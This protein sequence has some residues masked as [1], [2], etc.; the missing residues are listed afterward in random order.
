[1]KIEVQTR[2]G[3]NRLLDIEIPGT[4]VSGEINRAST[5]MA[6]FARVPGFRPG[7]VP[8]SVIKT[9]YKTE[10]RQE[11]L[12]NLLP[13]AVETAVE[14]HKLRP[15]GEPNVESLEFADDNTLK[16]GVVIEIYPEFTLAEYKGL[17]LTKKVF[18]ITDEDVERAIK[19]LVEAEAELV[20]VDDEGREATDGDFVSIDLDGAYVEEEGH[21][22]H[23]HHEPIKATDVQIEIGGENVQS[24]FSDALRGAKVGDTRTFT[25]V[26]K[27]ESSAPEFAGHTIEYTARV[28][29]I[30]VREVPEFD[31]EFASQYG[32][33]EH[34]TADALR[35][36][37]RTNLEKQAASRTERAFQDVLSDALVNANEFP[38][39]AS[40]VDTFA[41]ERVDRMIQ[42]FSQQ[43]IDPREL[44]LD[45]Q[46]VSRSAI[47]Q[48]EREVRGM[49]I[50]DRIAEAE[51]INPTDEDVEAEI[52]R[53]AEAL[54]QPLAQLR[55]RL[56]KEGG[57]DSIRHQMRSRKALDLVVEAARVTVEEVT[58]LHA[59]EPKAEDAQPTDGEAAVEE[60]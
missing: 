5:E 32:E 39:P 49:F 48:A 29:A 25:V 38:V 55:A 18:K 20:A 21:E 54:N 6:R 23:H 12:R 42:M 59:G 1:M 2:E 34:E 47:Q 60:S 31:D 4:I 16:I 17:E 44:R 40:M 22:H 26:Y 35:A 51:Q 14:Q 33:G 11:A 37:I 15:V 27:A 7:R 9:R 45:W 52:G 30:R 57:A 36:E 50:I 41:R 46:A 8:T 58:G 10:L 56:T 19:E 53:L 43:G 28:A 3:C 24:E 13:S